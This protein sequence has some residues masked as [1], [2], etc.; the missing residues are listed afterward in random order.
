MRVAAAAA[1]CGSLCVSLCVFSGWGGAGLSWRRA[2]QA[3]GSPGQTERRTDGQK[4][5]MLRM[6]GGV[7]RLPTVVF[8]FIL[9]FAGWLES[10]GE[11]SARP[12]NAFK[13]CE[14]RKTSESVTHQSLGPF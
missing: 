10:D 4:N 7:Q 14:R 6:T 8:F 3:A 12:A 5:D 9:F 11:T 1:L 2:A 13:K